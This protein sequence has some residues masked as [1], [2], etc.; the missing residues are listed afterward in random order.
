MPSR[1]W[2]MRHVLWPE[3]RRLHSEW[4]VSLAVIV[5]IAIA[6]GFA[7]SMYIDHA[8]EPGRLWQDVHHD[9]NSHFNFGLDLAL[10]LRNFDLLD[11]LQHL[12]R[13]RVWPP[14][15]GLA[16]ASVLTLGGID[17][18]LAILPS[19]I[20][21]AATIALSFLIALRLLPDRRSGLTA[22]ALAV[23]FAL[24]S[25]AF[26]LIT[27]DVML[28]GLG[29][30]LTALCLYAYL[31]ARGGSGSERWWGILALSLTALFF[32]KSNYWLLTVV[33]LAIAH[34][35]EDMRC[36]LERGHA[37]L[38][39]IDVR[40]VAR[41]PFIVAA[42]CLL[43][44]VAALYVRGPTVVHVFG[45]RVSLYPPENLVTVVWWV[46]FLRAVRLWRANRA[47]IDSIGIAGRRL[48]YWHAV[49][50][51]LSF[52]LPKRLATVLWYVG[53][54]HHAAA[55]Y[56]PLQAI[57]TQWLAFSE[58]FHV[59]PWVAALVA[60]L[61]LVAA[62]SLPRLAPGARAV[63]LLAGLSAVAVVLHPQQQWR[64]QTTWLFA[65][66][67][68]AG[69]GGAII[70]A[71][72]VPSLPAALRIG[73]AA[74]A[75]GA[76]AIA[77]S[78]YRWTSTAYTAAIHPQPGPSD[79]G[80]AKAYLP[81]LAG[82]RAVGF[83]ATFAR[84]PFFAWTVHEHC[85]CRTSVDMPWTPPF[86]A[87]EDYRRLGADWLRQTR[88]EVVV[89][90][91]TPGRPDRYAIPSLGLDYDRLSGF[92]DAIISDPQFARIATEPVPALGAT[93]T[94]WRRQGG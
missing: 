38:A 10:S 93:V 13:A 30:A 74:A 55:T 73:A 56:D 54:T 78:Q 15:H 31:R 71:Q 90:V 72:M 1:R 25:P 20:G 68:L 5:V 44:L 51:A 92:V 85:R 26:R 14:V 63:V 42:A 82:A 3:W 39:A 61:A 11:F 16:L 87:R 50:V 34:L 88:S 36:W 89:V 40:A 12:E 23:T 29:A 52:L 27:A 32:E 58:G 24:A 45:L 28:E 60:I 81:H 65:V 57:D 47:A 80:L 62:L 64:F 2:S 35:S 46:L 4:H 48:F 53:P 70:L 43:L 37:R 91:E 77:E 8:A 67:A 59:A 6:A 94:I 33:P 83:L 66:W 86:L 9:R 49:P 69:A 21:W 41:D 76:L 75:I 84:E 18:R 79:L 22:G 17:V 7:A 19:L